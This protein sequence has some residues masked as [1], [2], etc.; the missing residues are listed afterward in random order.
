MYKKF[1]EAA[2]A[3]GLKV[4]QDA[5]YNHLGINHWLLKDLPAKDWLHQWPTYTN[6]SYKDQP[7]PDPYASKIDREVTSNSS[8]RLSTLTAR[9]GSMS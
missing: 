6:T 9:S 2:H 1:V 7:L 3:S 8:I 5:V 4:V